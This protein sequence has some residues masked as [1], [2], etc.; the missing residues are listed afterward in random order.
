MG[1][2][3][4]GGCHT[5]ATEC[6]NTQLIRRAKNCIE[7][8]YKLRA[9]IGKLLI[10]I[11]CHLIHL[12]HFPLQNTQSRK[13]NFL[14]LMQSIY[15][16]HLLYAL[17][18]NELSLNLRIHKNSKKLQYFNFFSHSPKTEHFHNLIM[19][20]EEK[21]SKSEIPFFNV[22][23]WTGFWWSCN[24]RRKNI[25]TASG[26]FSSLVFVFLFYFYIFCW[27]FFF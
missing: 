17:S 20:T 15:I 27:G 3:L 26:L 16:N 21:W 2:C 8:A 24:S 4:L 13:L 11:V 5:S 10:L 6:L 1:N 19:K 25:W 9:Y 14:T 12:V 23:T 18:I 7:A 22:K